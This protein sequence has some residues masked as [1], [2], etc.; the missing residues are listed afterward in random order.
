M[1]RQIHKLTSDG[2]IGGL[3]LLFG[4]NDQLRVLWWVRNV[5]AL[6]NYKKKMMGMSSLPK[7]G[8]NVKFASQR[9][10]Y[11]SL[12]NLPMQSGTCLTLQVLFH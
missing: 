2:V 5:T 1:G 6:V 10:V 11:I 8:G 9:L 3:D 4:N 12:K 7:N